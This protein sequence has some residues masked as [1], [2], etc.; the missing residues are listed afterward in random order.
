MA[1]MGE[2]VRHAYETAQQYKSVGFARFRRLPGLLL[3]PAIIVLTHR[4]A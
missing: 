3:P 4:T 2:T 1:T